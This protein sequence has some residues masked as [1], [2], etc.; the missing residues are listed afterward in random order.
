MIKNTNREKLGCFGK[1]KHKTLLSAQHQHESAVNQGR[2][3][4]IY[5]C[6]DCLCY[7]I[8]TNK[9]ERKVTESRIRKPKDQNKRMRQE[10]KNIRTNKRNIR[11][12]S[13]D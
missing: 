5:L 12:R 8:G 9:N 6:E 10:N 13:K 2:T 7:H 1:T 11:N 3:G 4:H